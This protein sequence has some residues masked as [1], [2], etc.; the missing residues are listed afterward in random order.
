MRA[1]IF[2]SFSGRPFDSGRFLVSELHIEPAAFGGDREIA[3]AE[4][5]DEVKR[6]T[7][8][9]LVSQPHRVL[10]NGL[11]DG[12]ADMR[13]RL[14]EPVRGHEASERLVGALEVVGLH[15]EAEPA[16][17]VGVV[18]KHRSRQELVPERLPESLDLP[19]RLRVLGPALDVANAVLAER[20]F[21]VRL[22]S[23]GGVLP[24]L[25][26][27]DLL[28]LAPGRD[29]SRERLEHEL[30]PLMV[31]QR[32][33]D[34][35]PRVVVHERREV[36]ALLS[37]EQERED[38]RLPHLVRLGAL[39]AARRVLAGGDRLRRDEPR[40]MEDLSNL[41]LRDSQGVEAR[42]HVPDPPRAHLRVLLAQSDHRLAERF[43]SRLLRRRWPALRKGTKP[44][45]TVLPVGPHPLRERR[46]RQP[47]RAGG[48]L[49]GSFGLHH[50]LHDPQ[51]ELEREGG[52][53][54]AVSSLGASR[55]F[56]ARGRRPAVFLSRHFRLQV[57]RA[58]AT[59]GEP[60]AR[61][62]PS[63]DLVA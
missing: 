12:R 59:S 42:E 28:R 6:L 44:I 7:R 56:P 40:L 25:I 21:E 33:G 10:L 24:S 57:R 31:R 29:P 30:G 17:A 32:V 35:E 48:R 47:E 50:Q 36:E 43:R 60:T 27:E 3:V 45:L 20:L 62:F 37:A 23:P 4:L 22:P 16:V 1:A 51:L 63:R 39:E 52:S 8:R 14:K 15:E 46:R 41:R 13:R 55:V 61:G 18:G 53:L 26:G 38:V 58:R 49:L 11:L 2:V 54:S 9:L 5:T 19:E 34:D